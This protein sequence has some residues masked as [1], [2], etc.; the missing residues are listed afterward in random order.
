MAAAEE[1]IKSK[2]ADMVTK[3]DTEVA[4]LSKDIKSVAQSVN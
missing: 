2:K 1:E 3:F 4:R